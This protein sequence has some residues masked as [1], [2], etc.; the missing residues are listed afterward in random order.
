MR[1]VSVRRRWRR[2]MRAGGAAT[3]SPHVHTIVRLPGT[4]VMAYI[5]QL[6]ALCPPSFNLELL[7][8]GGC[9]FCTIVFV[10]FI[11]NIFQFLLMTC[12]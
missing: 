2:L 10:Q 12:C 8:I 4:Y 3:L 6:F 1:L 11:Q 5:L 9:Y 7:G